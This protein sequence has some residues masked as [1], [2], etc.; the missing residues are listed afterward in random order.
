[1]GY[2]IA[3]VTQATAKLPKVLQMLTYK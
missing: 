3:Q 2:S 1:V